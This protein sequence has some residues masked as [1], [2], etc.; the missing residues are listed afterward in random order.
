VK[1]AW[2]SPWP[3]QRSGIA[4]RSAELVPL[5]ARRG[6]EIDVFVDGARLPVAPGPDTPPSAGA[7]RI[8]NAH[9]FVWRQQK[10]HYDL[11]V[12][13]IGN[14]HLHRYI[15]P[16]LFRYPG[17]AVVHDG[18]VHHARAAALKAAGRLDDYRAEVAWNHP[19]LAGRLDD[20]PEMALDELFYFRW[21]MI[22]SVIETARLTA[23]HSPGLLGQ[24]QQQWPDR[25]IDHVALGEGPDD[26]DVPVVSREFREAH[27]LPVSAPVFGV[28]GAL[29]AEKRVREILAAFA[30][31]RAWAPE[32]VLLLAGAAD[33]WLDLD[34][35]IEQLGLGTAV[36]L[37]PT[38]DDREF[39]RAIAA[40]D[41]VL[42][43]RWPTA[44]ETSGP[45]VRALALGRATVIMDL[46][47]QTHLPTL[48][49]RTW[50]RH[51]P[52]SDLAPNADDR[53]IAVAVDVVDF[54]HS[55][56]LA[57]RRLGQ[58][59]ALRRALGDRG[60]RWWEREHTVARM[61]DDYERVIERA[62]ITP[63]PVGRPDWPRHLR[64][65]PDA[66][67]RAIL[68]DPLWR[69]ASV[70]ARLA[71]LDTCSTIDGL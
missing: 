54:A 65:Q 2:F 15:W 32:A 8:L 5:L 36:R 46:P 35:Y 6:H 9:E 43:L 51:A 25:P 68:Q 1:I 14:S 18:R 16:Y 21:P 39:D 58:D 33:P 56:R 11:P 57:L 10:G 62:R 60:R 69:D 30:D 19:A 23:V 48:D 40:T 47:H 22:R 34:N 44:L 13:Q 27:G 49:P 26:M 29:T 7:P 24:L 4:G 28:F 53:A 63:P 61:V 38:L 52:C 59:A 12:Y 55:F 70:D 37:L 50:H 3:P 41:V 31:T 66:G 20:L 71:T 42:S 45:W 17:L 64:P 67:A